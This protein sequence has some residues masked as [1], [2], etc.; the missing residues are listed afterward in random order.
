MISGIIEFNFLDIYIFDLFIHT[1]LLFITILRQCD[2]E[3]CS[4]KI[5]MILHE[6]SRTHSSSTTRLLVHSC[7][8]LEFI[9]VLY[10]PRGLTSSSLAPHSV[11]S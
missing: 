10:P 1:F 4:N 8:F 6:H 7:Q 9:T 3:I 2:P 5:C 11:P